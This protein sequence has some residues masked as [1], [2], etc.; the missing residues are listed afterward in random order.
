MDPQIVWDAV[1]EQDETVDK[2]TS[3]CQSLEPEEDLK[4]CDST[5]AAKPF[6]PWMG[7]PVFGLNR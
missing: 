3:L 6:G 1:E 7:F 5:T 4:R 2:H